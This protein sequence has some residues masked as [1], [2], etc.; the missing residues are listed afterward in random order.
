MKIDSSA[1]YDIVLHAK[2]T[3]SF[4]QFAHIAFFTHKIHPHKHTNHIF[5]A[6]DEQ[7]LRLSTEFLIYLEVH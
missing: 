1:A 2:Y 3:I 6:K 4:V 5:H 7:L